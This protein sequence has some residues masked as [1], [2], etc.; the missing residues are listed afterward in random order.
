MG[1]DRQSGIRGREAGQ[2]RA[3]N[4]SPVRSIQR[5]VSAERA[6][7]PHQ[8]D[9]ARRA[10]A[11][12]HVG[13]GAAAVARSV[14]KSHPV[15][16]CHG[17]EGVGRAGIQTVAD[18][19]P[20]LGPRIDVLH[21]GDAREDG[22]I[23]AV[24]LTHKTKRVGRAPDVAPGGGHGEHTVGHHGIGV[25]CAADNA[26]RPDVLR[27]PQPRQV[28]GSDVGLN[29]GGYALGRQSR[30]KAAVG[31]GEAAKVRHAVVGGCLIPFQQRGVA[32]M[33]GEWLADRS[34]VAIDRHNHDAAIGTGIVS[35]YV[36][37]RS[38]SVIG[39]DAG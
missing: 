9:P 17:H 27:R 15:V 21:R 33:D 13:A 39:G 23:G 24:G 3:S 5:T 31:N 16:R 36:D 20:G 30:G 37:A 7:I 12:H 10:H 14:L 25:G 18:H 19:D 2:R 8:L 38:G 35:R 1:G 6:A 29:E 26:H 4:Q 32:V 28:G 34:V 11:G 22:A